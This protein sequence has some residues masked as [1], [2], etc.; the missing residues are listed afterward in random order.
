MKVS[1]VGASGY[2]GGEIL[3]ILAQHPHAEIVSLTSRQYAGEYVHKAHPNMKGIISARFT[4]DDPVKASANADVV[5]LALPHKASVKVVPK[6][7]ETGIRIIDMSA[8]FRL[9]TPESYVRW[10]GYEHPNPELL[11]KFVYGLPE[12]HREELK[13]AKYVSA[14]GCMASAS[15]IG[16]APLVK[17]YTPSS[18]IIV[19]AKIGSSGAGGKPSPST[20]FSE[21]YGV[22]RPYKPTGHR[23]TAEIEQELRFVSGKNIGVA[24]SAHAVNQVRGILTTSHFITDTGTKLPDVWKAYRDF[25]PSEPFVRFM[26]DKTGIYRFPDPKVV[27]GSNFADIGFD[28]DPYI[29]RVVV[30][31]AID[32]LLKG[33]AG[34]AVQSMNLMFGFNE[35]EG[36]N[37][38][39]L[40]PV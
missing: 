23:H 19:D 18:P 21:R 12:L 10:Y 14:P 11:E 7:I 34:S 13:G 32:N 4:G 8:D 29:N 1:V 16:L 31:T 22:I 5:F 36:L 27:I 38:A 2:V 3:R 20:H 24:M 25:Y 39:A 15:I 6:L 37:M 33:A 28:I 30:L 40:H 26:M 9:K 17:K 35:R